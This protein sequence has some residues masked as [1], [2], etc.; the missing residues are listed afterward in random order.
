MVTAQHVA[1]Q[2]IA[3]MSLHINLHVAIRTLYKFLEVSGIGP[4]YSTHTLLLTL[5]LLRDFL[6]SAMHATIVEGQ[7]LDTRLEVIRVHLF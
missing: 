3:M 1:G 7:Y 5:Q 6:T 4:S 2:N